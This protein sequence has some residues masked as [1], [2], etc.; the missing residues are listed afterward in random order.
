MAGGD[1][2]LAIHEAVP[3]LTDEQI[4]RALLTVK[5]RRAEDLVPM[6]GLDGAPVYASRR[7]R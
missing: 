4:D 2:K 3:H 7:G 1:P 6:L 5:R